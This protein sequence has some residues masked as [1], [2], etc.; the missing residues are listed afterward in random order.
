MRNGCQVGGTNDEPGEPAPFPVFLLHLSAL[1]FT[2]VLHKGANI[3]PKLQ[4][5]GLLASAA[6]FIFLGLIFVVI[7]LKYD[8]N[9]LKYLGYF[10]VPG[11]LLQ[12]IVLIYYLNK[13]KQ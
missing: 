13:K 7:G 5:A 2:I 4:K 11:G 6:T 12:L 10:W 3:M 9:V 8:N 1:P